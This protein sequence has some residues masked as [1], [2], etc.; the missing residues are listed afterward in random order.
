LRVRALAPEV[1]LR[2]SQV[3]RDAL[4]EFA[5]NVASNDGLKVAFGPVSKSL[6]EIGPPEPLRDARYR[7]ADRLQRAVVRLT[8]NR[9]LCNDEEM[10]RERVR[11]QSAGVVEVTKE[12]PAIRNRVA[13]ADARRGRC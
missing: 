3:R 12:G 13:R 10:C 5:P 4:R 8:L 9:A 1:A 7:L 6:L 2:D 11:P